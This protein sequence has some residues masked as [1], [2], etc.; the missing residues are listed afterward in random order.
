[1]ESNAP[2]TIAAVAGETFIGTVV[3]SVVVVVAGV[4]VATA[5]TTGVV[6][7]VVNPSTLSRNENP[8]KNKT[9]IK[10]P[11]KKKIG[12]KF[13]LFITFIPQ[14]YY[15]PLSKIFYSLKGSSFSHKIC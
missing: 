13:R 12:Y 7:A 9:K 11:D 14:L 8:E 3:A 10:I 4:A 15:I 6:V 5:F 1:M 2:D